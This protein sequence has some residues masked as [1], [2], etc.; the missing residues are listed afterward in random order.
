LV[1]VWRSGDQRGASRLGTVGLGGLFLKTPKPPAA[2]STVELVI[3]VSPGTPGA[4]VRARAVVYNVKPGEGMGVKFVHMLG[5]DRLRLNQF[6]HAQFTA[7]KIQAEGPTTEIPPSSPAAFLSPEEN[8]PIPSVKPGTSASGAPSEHTISEEEIRKFVTLAHTGTHYQL[9]GITSDSSKDQ[10]KRGFYLLAR[11]FHPDRHMDRPHW[12]ESLQ[13]LMGAATEAY[14]ILSDDEERFGYDKRLAS[15]T[16]TESQETVQQCVKIASD[17][18]RDENVAGYIFWMRKCVHNAPA[19]AKYRVSLA[20][21]LMMNEWQRWEAIQ[22]F[23]KAIELDPFDASAYLQFGVLY[24][25]M[26]LP[27]RARTL[28]SK[29]LEI[30]PTHRAANE[31][32]ASLDADEKKKPSPKLASLFSGK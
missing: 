25:Q 26:R 20:A 21:G 17:C 32:L 18:L 24:E 12:K 29:V 15:G 27:W 30:D 8:A 2:G 4:D 7:A 3:Q 22:Q 13:E 28:Y 14:E 19:V 23:E 9:L 5:D 10:V 1:V 16:R 31:R 6:L 11:K